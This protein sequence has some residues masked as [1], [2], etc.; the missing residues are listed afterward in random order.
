MNKKVV[1]MFKDKAVGRQI[2]EFV[3]LRAK[4]YSYVLEGEENKRCKGVKEAVK[5]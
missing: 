4:L 5:K 1:G 2:Q 3:G